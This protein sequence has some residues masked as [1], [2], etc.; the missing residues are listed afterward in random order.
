MFLIKIEPGRKAYRYDVEIMNVTR[1]RSQTRG[2]DDGQRALNRSLCYE[3]ITTAYE[4]T[5]GFGMAEGGEVVYDCK[6]TM[7]TSTPIQLE[8]VSRFLTLFEETNNFIRGINFLL[9]L[10]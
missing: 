3:L 10:L 9:K 5:N 1:Q 2:A 7:Y 8:S 6:C 4:K